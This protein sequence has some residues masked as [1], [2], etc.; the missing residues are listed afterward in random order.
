MLKLRIARILKIIRIIRVIRAVKFY[1]LVLLK[2][3]IRDEKKKKREQQQKLINQQEQR[4][5]IPFGGSIL[6]NKITN[7]ISSKTGLIKQ[8]TISYIDYLI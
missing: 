4:N 5:N 1:K 3:Q 7:L 6:K 8:K 2:E